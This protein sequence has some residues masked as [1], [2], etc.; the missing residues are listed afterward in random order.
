[1]SFTL[2]D[3][4]GTVKREVWTCTECRWCST[5]KHF[6]TEDGEPVCLQCGEPAEFLEE[7]EKNL[8]MKSVDYAKMLEWLQEHMGGIGDTTI[9][10]IREDFPN[11]DNFLAACEH[12]YEEAEYDALTGID[13]IGESYARHKLA[14]GVAEY[15]GWED[16]KAEPFEFEA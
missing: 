13:G 15:K 9:S 5:K 14:L 3:G 11:G 16:G 6:P 2:K 12:A 4:N 8:G 1:M 7:I 10:N